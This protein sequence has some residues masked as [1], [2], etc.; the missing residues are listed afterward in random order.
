MYCGEFSQ[1]D[2]LMKMCDDLAALFEEATANDTPI[3]DIVGDDAPCRSPRPSWPS[4]H[5]E[6]GWQRKERERLVA[7]IAPAL[8]GGLTSGHDLVPALRA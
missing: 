4:F 6:G 2:V 7:A 8:P 5:T 1:G 3:R